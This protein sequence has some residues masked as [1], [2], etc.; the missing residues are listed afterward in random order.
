MISRRNRFHGYNSLRYVYRHGKVSRGSM[1]AVKAA[2]NDKRHHY[3][4]AVVVARK[5][6]KSAVARNRMRRRLYELIRELDDRIQGPYD[7]AIT[8]F[9]NSLLETT[10]GQLKTQLVKQLKEVGVIK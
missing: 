4:A 7:I 1:F 6:D 2:Y 8:V 9:Q 10:H 5:V 3:R